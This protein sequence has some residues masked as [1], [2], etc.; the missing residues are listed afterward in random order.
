MAIKKDTK[1]DTYIDFLRALGLLLLIGVHVNAPEW[2]KPLRS[3]DVP[4]M[5]FISAVCYK[6]I[7]GGYLAYGVKRLK[8]IYIPV[9]IFLCILFSITGI[10]STVTDYSIF[11]PSKIVGSFLLLN[12]PSIGY[13]WIMRV[14]L[15]M[16]LITPF[17]DRVVKK[18][19]WII[20]LLIIGLM[21]LL[22]SVIVQSVYFIV[23]P[24]IS[25]IFNEIIVYTIG[26]SPLVMLGLGISQF[27]KN[28]LIISILVLGLSVL[29]CTIYN[30]WNFIPNQ[31]KYPPTTFYIVYG[32]F[33]SCLL[34]SF[35]NIL[36]PYILS[37]FVIYLSRNSMWLYLWHIVPVYMIAPFNCIPNTWFL[38]YLIVVAIA[39]GLY[40]IYSQLTVYIPD[41]YRKYIS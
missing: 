20:I 2:Y 29:A 25:F 39:I 35:K 22:Q 27:K 41:R 3:F 36:S 38:R 33:A 28:E 32:L 23:N 26:Y 37:P 6:P 1:R 11:T 17:L 4:L 15:L 8:R 13:V 5:V 12:S 34:W 9:F 31:Y 14:F 19:N 18:V 16:A 10:V 7:Q 24:A 40:W 21:I 30:D